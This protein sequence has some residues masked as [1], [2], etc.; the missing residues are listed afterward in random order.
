[1]CRRQAT[2]CSSR[3]PAAAVSSLVTCAVI[4]HPPAELHHPVAQE[5]A[6]GQ[7]HELMTLVGEQQDVPRYL[8]LAHRRGVVLYRHVCAH[9]TPPGITPPPGRPGA[10]GWTTSRTHAPRRRTAGR[11]P[12]PLARAA[13]RRPAPSR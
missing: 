2:S 12:V 10:G 3:P 1:M 6:V 8:S 4:E 13:P 9:R 11:P 5:L 7:L